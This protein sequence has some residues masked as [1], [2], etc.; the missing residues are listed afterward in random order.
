MGNPYRG[1]LEIYNEKYSHGFWVRLW[2]RYVGKLVYGGKETCGHCKYWHWPKNKKAASEYWSDRTGKWE[3]AKGD[4]KLLYG[5]NDTLP[6][7]S[8]DRFHPRRKYM[9]RVK[10]L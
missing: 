8:C 9:H 4:C 2:H 6:N 3:K 5:D 10:I 1:S 7:E